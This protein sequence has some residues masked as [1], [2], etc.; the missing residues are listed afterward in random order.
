MPDVELQVRFPEGEVDNQYSTKV[1]RHCDPLHR[2]SLQLIRLDKL[3]ALRSMEIPKHIRCMKAN[4]FLAL[5]Y[6]TRDGHKT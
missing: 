4:Y 2:E 1:M 6:Y 3:E 5:I